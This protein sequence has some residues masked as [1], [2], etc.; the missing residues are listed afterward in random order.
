[1]V[2]YSGTHSITLRENLNRKINVE[3]LDSNFKFLANTIAS[4][5]LTGPTGPT[6][7]S[8]TVSNYGD[9]RVIVSDGT[10]YGATA[11]PNFLFTNNTLSI[12][13]TTSILPSIGGMAYTYKEIVTDS[14]TGGISHYDIS[15]GIPT[16]SQIVG[17]QLRVD[18]LI[19]K[20]GTVIDGSV[21]WDASFLETGATANSFTASYLIANNIAVAKN[22][23]VNKFLSQ[24]ALDASQFV[25]ISD[26][27]GI[28][29]FTTETSG[30][31]M[32]IGA[33][34]SGGGTFSA[35]VIRSIV[36]YNYFMPMGDAE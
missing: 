23:K 16:A 36:Y 21:R 5:G 1:M 25:N 20:G 3:E 6:G 15:L 35:G 10:P 30:L 34:S 32:R 13:G 28:Y 22:T 9:S 26:F 4:Y 27:T 29:N 33:S 19:A 17:V 2:T 11:Q 18:T 31:V 7:N 24:T 14:L 8:F 12:Y